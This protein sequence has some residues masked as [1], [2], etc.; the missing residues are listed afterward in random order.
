MTFFLKI[1]VFLSVDIMAS[2][3]GGRVNNFSNY[4]TQ[5]HVIMDDKS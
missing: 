1:P 5:R 4:K 3:Y 2:L